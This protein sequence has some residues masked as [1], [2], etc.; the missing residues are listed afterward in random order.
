MINDAEEGIKNNKPPTKT[1]IDKVVKQ[2]SS[3][4]YDD[5]K[6]SE[7]VNYVNGKIT[8][9]ELNDFVNKLNSKGKS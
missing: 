3:M 1:A 7:L 2:I 9:R 8:T 6:R 4:D 5:T